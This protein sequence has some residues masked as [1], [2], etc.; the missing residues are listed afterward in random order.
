MAGC[1]SASTLK[2]SSPSD[3]KTSSLLLWNDA[4]STVPLEIGADE[5][6]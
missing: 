4:A 2:P 6:D 5:V 3:A 1:C